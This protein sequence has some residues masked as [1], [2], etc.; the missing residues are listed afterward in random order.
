VIDS[1]TCN[2]S[3]TSQQIIL[4]LDQSDADFS[5]E[6]NGCDN[7]L[8]ITNNTVRGYN[9]YWTFGNGDTS[10]QQT[11]SY[12]YPSSGTF[13]IELTVNKGSLCESSIK[14][15]VTILDDVIPEFKLY[16]VFTPNNDGLNDCFQMDGKLI[17]CKEYKLQIFNRWGEKVFETDDPNDCWNGGVDNNIKILPQGTYFYL[18]WHGKNSDP[19]SGIV[20]LIK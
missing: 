16:N 14:K 11:P 7:Q 9:Y 2:I 18:V 12:Q 5:V 15:L 1:N 3:S 6:F 8:S 19:I 10:D 4:V 17:E 20:E 13:E